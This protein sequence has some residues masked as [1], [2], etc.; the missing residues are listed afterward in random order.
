MKTRRGHQEFR[1]ARSD[2]ER[3]NPAG[4][5]AN[6]RLPMTT[7]ALDI[8]SAAVA[9]AARTLAERAVGTVEAK[10][11]RDLVTDLDRA[12]EDDVRAF[13]A[14]ET[15]EIGFLGEESGGTGEGRYWLLDPI[16]GTV[17]LVH[18]LPLVAVALALID[19]HG[20]TEAAVIALPRSGAHYSAA[21][22]AGAHRDGTPIHASTTDRLDRAVVSL[23]D[24]AVG[25]GAAEK[26]AERLAITGRLA[27]GAERLRM[28]GSACT[29][30]SWVADGTLDA[31]LI[32][33][34]T[35][36]DTLA[37]VLIAR[38]AGAIAVD[39]Q[40]RPHTRDSATTV[41]V[42]PALLASLLETMTPDGGPAS[43]S[44]A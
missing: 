9:R 7:D 40:G 39:R 24:F 41:V 25:E 11:E 37:G 10:G 5:A 16:D 35:P 19:E 3:H 23:G 21:R 44:R 14:R 8:A 29:A 2:A 31:T 20:D 15:P 13:L 6:V 43:A 4:S 34:N 27:A 12:I 26:N 18:G 33:H 22:G 42:A 36:W 17:N 32:H 38:E 30:L 1:S 28:I